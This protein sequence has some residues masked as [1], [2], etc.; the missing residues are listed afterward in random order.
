MGRAWIRGAMTPDTY[1]D[2]RE[3]EQ[4]LIKRMVRRLHNTYPEGKVKRIIWF[5]DVVDF[6]YDEDWT[7]VNKMV[8]K[9]VRF[10]SELWE[11]KAQSSGI[12]LY[13]DDFDELFWQVVWETIESYDWRSGFYLLETLELKFKSRALD[14]IRWAKRSKRVHEYTAARLPEEIDRDARFADT[15]NVENE[16]VNRMTVEG[17]FAEESLTEQERSLLSF[18]YEKPDAT[19]AEMASALGLSH[20]EQARRLHVGLRRKLAPY[21]S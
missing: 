20:K 1:E 21:V 18:L 15:Q 7:T 10:Y 8:G 11:Q 3:S 12:R 13:R 2:R 16:V 17:M 9:T 4:Q 6:W 5:E 14:K 19:L